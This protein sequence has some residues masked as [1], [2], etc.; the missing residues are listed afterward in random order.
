[1]SESGGRQS[2]KSAAWRAGVV[3]LVLAANLAGP[4]RAQTLPG[5][6]GLGA[7]EP[8][9]LRLPSER[10]ASALSLGT[11]LVSAAL[12]GVSGAFGEEPQS[13]LNSALTILGA[14]GLYI[15]PSVGGFYGG[16]WG[17]GL[18]LTGL[19]LGV[20]VAG[21]AYFLANDEK[22]NTVA[23]VLMLGTLVGSAIYEC[24][25]VK[26]AVRRRNAAR[27]EKRGPNLAVAPFATARGGG[28]Q[29]RLSF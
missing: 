8:P 19:R 15:G 11:V 27:L 10:T 5:A 17:R 21:G 7:P 25:T 9:E 6:G 13:E 18:L 28:L 14:I 3:V 22:D 20:T 24:A 16:C 26:S 2:K 1:M 4:L 29:V 23:G 12:L